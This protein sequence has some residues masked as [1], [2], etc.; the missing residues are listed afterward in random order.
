MMNT[1]QKAN[2]PD[3][4]AKIVSVVFHPVFMPLYGL[5]ILLTAPTFL[6]YLQ[7]DA[8]RILF[9]VVLINNVFIPL[10]LLPFLRYRNIISSYNID[11]RKE[12]IIPLL[13]ASILYCTTSFII[14]RFQIPFF[15]GG[16]WQRSRTNYM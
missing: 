15:L 9:L 14:F 1:G 11:E 7:V 10:A 3:T 5:G 4:L 6:K 12:R 16:K 2:I 8:R 13:T